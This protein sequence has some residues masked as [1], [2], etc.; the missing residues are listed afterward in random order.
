MSLEQTELQ[1]DVKSVDG[2]ERSIRM[3]QDVQ[4]VKDALRRVSGKPRLIATVMKACNDPSS[5]IWIWGTWGLAI[6]SILET[7]IDGRFAF[8]VYVQNEKGFSLHK[9]SEIAEEWARERG[10][11]RIAGAV[12]RKGPW[13]RLTGYKPWKLVIAKEL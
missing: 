5:S 9:M 8:F 6:L 12:E 11:E 10:A 2:R 4:D 7:A 3:V 13:Y 1:L